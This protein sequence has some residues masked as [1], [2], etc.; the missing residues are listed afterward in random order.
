M[1]ITELWCTHCALQF[2]HVISLPVRQ[3]CLALAD[4]SL[5]G[6]RHFVTMALADVDPLRNGSRAA[7]CARIYVS[8]MVNHC[9]CMK[10]KKKKR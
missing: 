10:Q 4:A 9:V 2:E 8:S 1:S 5:C 7:G 6:T 3:P